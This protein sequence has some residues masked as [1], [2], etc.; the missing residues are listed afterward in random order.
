MP[1]ITKFWHCR[2]REGCTV[3][4]PTFTQLFSQILDLCSSYTNPNSDPMLSPQHIFYQDI[5]NPSQLLMITGYQ[6]EQLMLEASEDYTHKFREKMFEQVQHIW[7]K[8]VD[9]DVSSFHPL[10]NEQ[11]IIT[12]TYGTA[13]QEWKNDESVGYWDVWPETEQAKADLY[14]ARTLGV[15]D[16]MDGSVWVQVSSG[17]ESATPA[18]GGKFL[19]R[20]IM[21]R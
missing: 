15:K 16:D 20:E 8:Q 13:P 17:N 6:S 9:A 10:Q 4:S 3:D 7:I 18:K 5:N 11:R 14:N 2:L 1:P 12:V 21:R 19:L